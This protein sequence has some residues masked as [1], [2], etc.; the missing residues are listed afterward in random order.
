MKKLKKNGNLDELERAITTG[1][2]KTKCI[3]IPRSLDGRL[4]VR[5]VTI[6]AFNHRFKNV[7]ILWNQ[8]NHIKCLAIRYCATFTLPVE[9]CIFVCKIPFAKNKCGIGRQNPKQML[10]SVSDLRC[11]AVRWLSEYNS[12]WFKVEEFYCNISG[13]KIGYRSCFRRHS[14]RTEHDMT[15]NYLPIFL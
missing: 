10:K 13:C 3:T 14:D 9:Y 4:Q 6:L 2:S 5:N 11:Y 12:C 7:F 1:E 15:G 8:W